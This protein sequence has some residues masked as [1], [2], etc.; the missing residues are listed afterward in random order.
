LSDFVHF[1]LAIMSPG[2]PIFTARLRVN[3]DAKEYFEKVNTW[4]L[5]RKD[6]RFC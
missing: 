4:S 1:F 3:Q 6:M 2:M 5:K